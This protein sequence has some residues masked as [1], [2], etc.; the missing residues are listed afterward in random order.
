MHGESLNSFFSIVLPYS[1]IEN[2]LDVLLCFFMV[3]DPIISF[4]PLLLGLSLP[5]CAVRRLGGTGL[6]IEGIF[7]LY[8]G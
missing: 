7:C 5:L 6:Q 8:V 4:P 1:N 3:S 2:R